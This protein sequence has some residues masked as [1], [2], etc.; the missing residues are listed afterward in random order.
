MGCDGPARV[1][2]VED[3][4]A[5]A[6]LYVRALVAAGHRVDHVANGTDGLR[7]LHSNPY[8][9]VLSDVCMPGL[10]GLDLL[11]EIR[12]KWPDIPVILVTAQLDADLYSRAREIGSVRYL[13]KPV[14]LEKLANAVEHGLKLRTTL[15]RSQE[16]RRQSGTALSSVD[17]AMNVAV[18][19]VRGPAEGGKP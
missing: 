9:L 5:L 18:R 3:E 12:V 16:R 13:L 7:L 19:T 6:R 1:L 11:N 15:L 14:S 17:S 4:L 2:V 8:D 10:S